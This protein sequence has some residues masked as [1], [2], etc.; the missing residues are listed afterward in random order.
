MT[1]MLIKGDGKDPVSLSPLLFSAEHSLLG[2]GISG[3]ELMLPLILAK[4]PGIIKEN[5]CMVLGF[6]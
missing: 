1:W 4:G 5:R 3:I 2:E 6:F